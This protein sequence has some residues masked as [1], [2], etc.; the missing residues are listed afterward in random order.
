MAS[1]DLSILEVAIFNEFGTEHTPERSFIRAYVDENQDK[2]RGWLK[3]LMPSV[4]KGARTR[5]QV[6]QLIG[7]KMVAEI[8]ARISSGISPANAPGTIIRKGSS[9]PL[10][11][12]GALR[13]A[14]T[15]KVEGL[16]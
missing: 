9:T 10:I 15:F 13:S 4:I 6:L 11:D 7:V 16:E 2:I 5:E 3:A 8:Q 14:I 12:T 1:N